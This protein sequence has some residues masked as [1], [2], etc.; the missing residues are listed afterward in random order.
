MSQDYFDEFEMPKRESVAERKLRCEE[1]LK[2]R[3]EAGE[4][5]SPVFGAGQ[6]VATSFWGA[7]WVRNV[8]AYGDSEYWR[9]EGRSLLRNSAVIHFEEN[10]AKGVEKSDLFCF[11]MGK[12][13]EGEFEVQ[14]RMERVDEELWEELRGRCVGKVGSLVD[15]LSGELSEEVLVDVAKMESGLFPQ[16]EELMVSCNCA[17][18]ADL[19]SHGAAV[20][21][22]IGYRL[23]EDA[24][25]LFR[26]RGVKAMDLLGEVKG[27][28][29]GLADGKSE[30]G[31]EVDL[32]G[33]FGIDLEE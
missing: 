13:G 8:E 23:D 28:V 4:E 27:A 3:N 25:L 5:L 33:V 22:A 21:Y 19:C 15:V 30:L 2:R 6:V 9:R 10:V 20:L 24:E 12:L 14:V 32:G 31:D 17:E 26:L 1:E 7:S 18:D 29:E 16:R 11:V